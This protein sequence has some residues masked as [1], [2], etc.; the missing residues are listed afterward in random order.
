MAG[1]RN[2]VVN[3][4]RVKN[5]GF[6]FEMLAASLSAGLIS[7]AVC[8]PLYSLMV[9]AVPR[10]VIM[11]IM[12]LILIIAVLGTVFV[13]SHQMGTNEN[14]NIAI[15]L[16]AALTA[17]LLSLLFQW[18]YGIGADNTRDLLSARGTQGFISIVLG[19]LRVVFLTVIGVA[20]GVAVAES[21]GREEAKELI[22]IGSAVKSFIAAVLIE[23]GT[24]SLPGTSAKMG[25]IFWILTAATFTTK[26][27]GTRKKRVRKSL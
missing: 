1:R 2:K 15:L 9:F 8:W 4:R 23:F 25:I 22:Y 11:G 18:L 7:W 12:F 14:T 26:L 6:N 17:F 27:P 13:L 24:I 5:E 10:T 3:T 16:I 21:Y 20:I 19:I